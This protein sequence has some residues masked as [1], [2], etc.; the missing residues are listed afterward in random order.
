MK[1]TDMQHFDNEVKLTL[2]NI[3]T[4]QQAAIERRRLIT[5]MDEASDK[6]VNFCQPHRNNM[7]LVTDTIRESVEYKNLSYDY[8][9]AKAHLS[10]FNKLHK[11]KEYAKAFKAETDE[12]FKIKRGQK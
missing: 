4:P 5:A 11:G 8:Q 9:V 6:F 10:S 12:H 7:G 3:M 1:I 2:E